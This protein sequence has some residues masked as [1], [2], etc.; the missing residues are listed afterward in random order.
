MQRRLFIECTHTIESGFR[1][2]VQR[3]V[4]SLCNAG[5][6]NVSPPFLEIIPFAVRGTELEPITG[7]R[8]SEPVSALNGSMSKVQRELVRCLRKARNRQLRLSSLVSVG[9]AGLVSRKSRSRAT[10]TPND[11]LLLPDAYWAHDGIWPWVAEQRRAGVQTVIV[12]YDLIPHFHPDIYGNQGAEH[13]RGYLRNVASH[14]DLV[15]T[16]SETVAHDVRREFPALAPSWNPHNPVVSFPLGA[17]VSKCRGRVRS[18]IQTCFDVEPAKAPFVMVGTI[19]M[20]K[21]HD[22]ALDAMQSLWRN[23]FNASICIL[24]EPGWRGEAFLQRAR[25]HPEFGARLKIFHNVSDTELTHA[26]QKAR[27]VLFTSKCEGYGLPIVE[28]LYHGKPTF[29]TDTAIHR[30]VGRE[31]V[32]YCD[33]NSPESMAREIANFAWDEA[34]VMQTKPHRPITWASS[35]QSIV[36]ILEGHNAASN[37]FAA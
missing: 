8:L 3:V 15:L 27:G 23:N 1:T 30:E 36:K 17:E 21:N 33:L 11:I 28:S 25:K 31:H 29:V 35:L 12:V 14:A 26:Y 9:L 19:E 37:R 7:K 10:I 13:F 6:S 20:R 22:Y 32:I 24:G 34:R 18:A 4:R 5:L 2:G 16:I